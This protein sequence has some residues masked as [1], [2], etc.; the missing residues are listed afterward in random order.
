MFKKLGSVIKTAS[1]FGSQLQEIDLPKGNTNTQSIEDFLKY[2][3]ET[4]DTSIERAENLE[5][6]INERK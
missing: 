1:Y 4:L 6:K 3:N 2:A 5:K